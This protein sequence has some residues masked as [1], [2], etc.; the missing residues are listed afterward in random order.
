MNKKE[1]SSD[2]KRKKFNPFI[3]MAVSAALIVIVAV[4]GFNGYNTLYKTDSIIE[5]DVN[6]S[7]EFNLDEEGKIINVSGVNDD[8]NK[9][10]IDSLKG[11][12]LKEG[13][14]KLKDILSSKNY[15]G[16]KNSVFENMI[17]LITQEPQ[18][19]CFLVEVISGK[20]KNESFYIK[21]KLL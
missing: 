18:C 19:T 6:P 17:A 1:E 13:A 9:L 2:T 5:F 3:S 14:T 8:A 16:N 12:S 20:S 7:I 15:L 21:Y 11:L 10:D 4:A